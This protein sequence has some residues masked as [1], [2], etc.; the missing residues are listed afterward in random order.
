MRRQQPAY[1]QHFL[2]LIENQGSWEAAGGHTTAGDAAPCMPPPAE[3]WEG[4][5]QHAPELAEQACSAAD[6]ASALLYFEVRLVAPVQ[7][8]CRENPRAWGHAFLLD[9]LGGARMQP[10]WEGVC[11]RRLGASC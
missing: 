7:C 2:R 9:R 5:S 4:L 10:C 6:V 3:A 1:A 11:V 8:C